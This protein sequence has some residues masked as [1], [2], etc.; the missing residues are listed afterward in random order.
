VT[1]TLKLRRRAIEQKYKASIDAMYAT[2]SL[3]PERTTV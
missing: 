3:I 2:P 1:P